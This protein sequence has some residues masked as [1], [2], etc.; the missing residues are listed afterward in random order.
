MIRKKLPQ[1]V[2]KESVAEL[3]RVWGSPV[4]AQIRCEYA[5]LRAQLPGKRLPI[6]KHAEESMK[7]DNIRPFSVR[8]EMQLHVN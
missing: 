4:I 8:L 2:G 6:V 7:D 3:I 1:V 5:I